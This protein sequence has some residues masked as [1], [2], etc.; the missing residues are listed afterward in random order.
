PHS[1]GART[2]HAAVL[3]PQCQRLAE[4]RQR[5]SLGERPPR[6]EVG[7]LAGAEDPAG[8]S[9]HGLGD[10]AS[11]RTGRCGDDDALTGP[12][13]DLE[14]PAAALTADDAVTDDA[15]VDQ[16]LAT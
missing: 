5:V 2:T 12:Q 6:F 1:L 8:V 4:E 15:P 9:Q 11:R 7:S 13:R 16:H 3:N 10:L 14:R